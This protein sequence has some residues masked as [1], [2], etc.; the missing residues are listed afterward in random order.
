MVKRFFLATNY[1]S[2]YAIIQLPEMILSLHEH[3]KRR[4]SE[5]TCCSPSTRNRKERRI[6]HDSVLDVEHESSHLQAGRIDQN[7]LRILK[8]AII[9]DL[10]SKVSIMIQSKIHEME[11]K[12]IQLNNGNT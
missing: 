6:D 2:G 3:F 11:L 7:E 10:S 8:N 1:L 5:V 9:E 12:K 4:K